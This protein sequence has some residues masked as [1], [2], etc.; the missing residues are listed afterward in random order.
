M[1]TGTWLDGPAIVVTAVVTVILVGI[2][3][4]ASFNAAMVGLEPGEKR[5]AIPTDS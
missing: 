3:E 4:S 2:K 5:L 1:T